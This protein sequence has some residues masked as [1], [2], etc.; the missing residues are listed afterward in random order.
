MLETDLEIGSLEQRLFDALLPLGRRPTRRVPIEQS[1]QFVGN[2]DPICLGS[3]PM[4]VAVRPGQAN[5]FVGGHRLQFQL[6]PI[7]KS[8]GPTTVSNGTWIDCDY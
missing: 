1:H 2:V 5:T 6:N 7:S 3:R 8:R 4:C